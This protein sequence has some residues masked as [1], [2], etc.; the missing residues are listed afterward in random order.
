MDNDAPS[1]RTQARS[2]PT[3]E[4]IM[5]GSAAS[6]MLARIPTHPLDTVKARIQASRERVGVGAV[7]RSTLAAE[8]LAGFYRGF[9]AAFLLSAPAAC[10]YFT[11]YEVAKAGFLASPLA[12]AVPL[13]AQHFTA[14]LA[15][16][17]AS[18]VLWVPIDVVKERLQ[19]QSAAA[20][21]YR[22]GRHAVASILRAEGLPGLYRG[23]GATLASYGPFSALYFLFYEQLK[24]AA[25][26]L[27][28]GPVGG[29]PSPAT[30]SFPLQVAAACTAGGLASFLTSPLDLVKLRLQVVAR[31][32]GGGGVPPYAYSGIVDG[33]RRIVR[34]EGW[35]GLWRGAG[36][37]V[38]YHMPTTGLSMVLF[39]RCT[40]WASSSGL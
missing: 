15:A 6:G 22:S 7:A 27:Q 4:A 34:S 40:A 20:P 12:D 35:R 13:A 8:G 39:E 38:L 30:L 18:C 11:S 2:A 19:V 31:T 25:L 23:Y 26:G 24:A 1:A 37:R 33:L 3:L 10:V 5:A 32:A 9:A 36:A 29:G 16:E 14:G 28:G 17:A 21:V